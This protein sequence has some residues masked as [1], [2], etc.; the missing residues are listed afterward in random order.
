M[1]DTRE[2][3][4]CRLTPP[5]WENCPTTPPWSCWICPPGTKADEGFMGGVIPEELKKKPAE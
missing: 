4:K 3:P 5:V 1:I 2:L